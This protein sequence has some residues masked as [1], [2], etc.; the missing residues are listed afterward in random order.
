MKC[1]APDLEWIQNEKLVGIKPHKTDTAYSDFGLYNQRG[2]HWP[3]PVAYAPIR[4][5]THE[6]FECAGLSRSPTDVI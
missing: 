5:R 4:G 2:Y 6:R 1:M 3:T